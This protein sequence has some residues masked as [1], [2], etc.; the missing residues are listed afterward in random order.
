MVLKGSTAILLAFLLIVVSLPGCIYIPGELSAISF[1]PL[2]QTFEASPAIIK[3]GEYSTLSWAVTGA[4]KVYIDNNIGNVALKGSIPI[5]PGSTTYY[6][7]VASNSSGNSTARTQI[8]VTGS[9]QPQSKPPAIL[10]FFTDK[11][12]ISP[13]DSITL[14]WDTAETTLVTLEPGGTVS[15]QGSKTVYPY[16]TSDYILTASNPY[17]IVKNS[18]TVIV[19]MP[20]GSQIGLEKVV[21]LPAIPEE[22][23]S[24]VKNNTTYTIQE[25]ACAGDTS[26][27][28]AS[29]AF[30]SFDIAGIPANAVVHEAF[31]DLSSYTQTGNPSYTTSMWGNMGAIEIYYYQYGKLADLDIMT[32][33]RPGTLVS[34]GNITDYP[35]S[36]WRVDVKNLYNGETI[37]QNLVQSDQARCQF[38]IQFFT[39]TNWD[40]KSDMF[41]FDD[42]K[43]IVKYTTP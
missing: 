35:V 39:S 6:T 5:L 43:L 7:L 40:G 12:Y 26:A 1:L 9:A 28:L 30:L 20:V 2:V 16:V 19:N 18:L 27:N 41:C 37:V 10:S 38:R 32:Y 4:S 8:M 42:A 34:G 21:V 22:S 15:A 24:L 17:G 11:N 23:G 31:L 36:P 25:T 14:Y 29:R 13:G 33:N 3:A